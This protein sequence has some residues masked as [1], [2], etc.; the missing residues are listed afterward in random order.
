MVGSWLHRSEGGAR[1]RKWK[2]DLLTVCCYETRKEMGEAAARDVE[3]AIKTVLSQKETCNM[4]FAAAPSQNEVLASLLQS[5]I[6]WTRVQAFHMDEYIGLAPGA[7]QSFAMFLRNA[8]FGHLPFGRVEYI[9]AYAEPEE[10]ARRY[11]VLLRENPC[12]IVI[13]GIGENGHIAFNDPQAALFDDPETV[14]I[15]ELEEPCRLQQVHDGCFGALEDVPRR[16]LTLTIPALVSAKHV[17]CVVPG[18]TKAEAIKN[19]L[20]GPVSQSCP[21][22]ILRRHP[23]AILY[24]DV[25]S[26]SCT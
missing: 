13:M 22:S 8:L 12:D 24:L 7:P 2:K 25:D 20:E 11:A 14:K 4:I 3:A 5:Q 17:F 16:A 6:D 15:V 23:Q 1:M 18:A 10:E 9:S 26:A 21:A 19:T